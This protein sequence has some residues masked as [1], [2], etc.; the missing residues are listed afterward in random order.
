MFVAQIQFSF[1]SA[2]KDDEAQDIV[3]GILASM[4]HNGQISSNLNSVLQSAKEIS[5]YVSIPAKDALHRKHNNEWVEA[6][7]A[8]FIEAG[9]QRPTVVVLGADTESDGP[10]Q[11]DE[12]S[13]YV[14]FTNFLTRESP[15]RCASCFAPV[16]LYQIPPTHQ[17]EY[18]NLRSWESDYQSCDALQMGCTVLENRATRQMSRL[19]S[20][21]T[22]SGLENCRLIAAITK[23]PVYY[24]LY[25]GKGRSIKSEKKRKCPSC[26][27]DWLLKEP[28]HDKFDFK[29]D[30]CHLLSNIAFDV[31]E[32]YVRED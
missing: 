4:Y 30:K 24:Y 13:G 25:R 28:W 2:K 18:W 31:R 29:C 27:G 5:S 22:K 26:G 6:E 32:S 16:P 23:K 14:L 9:G 19:D 20:A 21:L 10:C 8:R 7:I 12:I 11:C 1:D 3:I 15:L 17:G